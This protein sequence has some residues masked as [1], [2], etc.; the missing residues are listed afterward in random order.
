VITVVTGASG[1]FGANLTRAL[2]AAGRKVRVVIH[3]DTRGVD[4]LPVERVWGDV[5]DPALLREALTGAETVYHC[6][7]K[8]SLTGVR[9]RELFEVNVLGPRN[10]ARACIENKVRRLIHVS[11]CHALSEHPLDRS[12]SEANGLCCESERPLPYGLS[13]ARGEREILDA[14]AEGLDAVIVN[15]SALVGPH[16]YKLSSMGETVRDLARGHF[17][18]LVPGTYDYVD[19]RDVVAA[20]IAAEVRGRRGERYLIGG[21]RLTVRDLALLVGEVTGTPAPRRTCPMWAARVAAPFFEFGSLLMG[22]RPNFSRA[23]LRVLRSNSTLD[24]S[25]AVSE[26]GHHPR[27]IRET[28]ADTVA[29][30]K[31]AGVLK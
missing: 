9:R 10:V 7:G 17:P 2:L 5:C 29:W 14:V 4:G 21:H 28:L 20:A 3:R 19:V 24:I 15:P 1:H 13:K 27:P 30:Q 26:L 11:S 22:R 6:A 23:S 18:A 16:D 12:I 8:I 25:K 31:E